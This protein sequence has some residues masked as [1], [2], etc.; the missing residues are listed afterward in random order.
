M[1]PSGKPLPRW[2]IQEALL[3]IS[4][5]FQHSR[6]ARPAPNSSKSRSRPRIT[7]KRNEDVTFVITMM[8]AAVAATKAAGGAW[9]RKKNK[10][11]RA[12]AP[13]GVTDNKSKPEEVPA[14][15]TEKQIFVSNGKT[16]IG[17][18]FGQS[19]GSRGCKIGRRRIGPCRAGIPLTAFVVTSITIE[20]GAKFA[21]ING[22]I[23]QEG[24]QFGLQLGNQTYQVTLKAIQD[25]RVIVARRD[26]EIVVP[27]RRKHRRVIANA[28]RRSTSRQE[29]TDQAEKLRRTR[30]VERRGFNSRLPSPP[31]HG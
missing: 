10:A 30:L 15:R 2:K 22:K 28:A 4:E 25:G 20:Q 7:F 21:I 3:A 27:L 9:R 6:H 11:Q 1:R 26:Q 19:A 12:G 17:I 8:F 13:T 23:M 18:P 24:Q 14:L 16:A 29:R 31:L 5:G